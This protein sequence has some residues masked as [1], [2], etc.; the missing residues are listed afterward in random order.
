MTSRCTGRLLSLESDPVQPKKTWVR[1]RLISV[2]TASS[3]S[4]GSMAA[5]RGVALIEGMS[6]FLLSRLQSSKSGYTNIHHCGSQS[7]S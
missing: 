7:A 4:P 6:R 1:P 5:S 3:R 2:V